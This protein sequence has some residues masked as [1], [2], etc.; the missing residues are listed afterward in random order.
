M[1][2]DRHH[3][4]GAL[5]AT[6]HLGRSPTWDCECCG[7][8]WPCPTLRAIPT[9]RLD[10]ST[11]LPVVSY[12]MPTAIRDLRGRPEGPEPPEIVK[13]FLWFLPLRDAEA[14]AIALRMRCLR[15]C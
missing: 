15:R 14:R 1:S 5:P 6:G 8:P 9:D 4:A 12:L 7:E 11:L 13:R 2:Q 3:L 10:R